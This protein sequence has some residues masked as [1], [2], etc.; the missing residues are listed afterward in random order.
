VAGRGDVLTGSSVRLSGN[1]KLR[2]KR[3]TTNSASAS[4]EMLNKEQECKQNMEKSFISLLTEFFTANDKKILDQPE[5]FKSLF[6][7]FSKNEFRA[8][9]QI[10]NQFLASKQ[11]QELKNSEDTDTVFL[12][13]ITERFHKAYLFDKS[14]CEMVVLAYAWFLGLIDKKI[15]EAGL[16][17][18]SIGNA[19]VTKVVT[20]RTFVPSNSSTSNVPPTTYQPCPVS[21]SNQA[22]V[23]KRPYMGLLIAGIIIVIFFLVFKPS[24]KRNE[25]NYIAPSTPAISAPVS[26][27]LNNASNAR[28]QFPQTTN[29]TSST[30]TQTPQTT[31]SSFQGIEW[32]YDGTKTT[33]INRN[34]VPTMFI[35]KNS[36]GYT[37]VNGFIPPGDTSIHYG[38]CTVVEVM[39]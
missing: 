5:R 10:F 24:N 35:C 1:T 17:K 14:T 23:Q 38:K 13:A 34:R 26:D 9:A 8:E 36:D 3:S 30:R 39:K 15:F 20:Q 31:T 16:G 33:F 11:A 19:P 32:Y 4:L 28:N 25:K 2:Q 27:T 37:E 22:P 29:N 6:L 21:S 18:G 7:D 12:K